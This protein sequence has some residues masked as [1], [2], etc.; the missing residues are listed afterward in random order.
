[1]SRVRLARLLTVS[2]ASLVGSLVL[3]EIVLRRSVPA[4]T[5]FHPPVSFRPDL[6]EEAPF[7]YRLRPGRVLVYPYPRR[8]PRRVTV[9]SNREGFRNRRD[10][11]DPDPRLRI[12]HRGRPDDRT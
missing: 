1:M 8:N 6:F 3:A 2:F 5:V 11:S 4:W 9:H 12:G 10:L 7:G